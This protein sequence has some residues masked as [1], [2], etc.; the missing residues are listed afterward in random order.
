MPHCL[1]HRPLPACRLWFLAATLI[2]KRCISDPRGNLCPVV[3]TIPPSFYKNSTAQPKVLIDRYQCRPRRNLKQDCS[4]FRRS[5]TGQ[6]LSCERG[7][8]SHAWCTFHS[9]SRGTRHSGHWPNCT[10]SMNETPRSPRHHLLYSNLRTNGFMW[11]S[12]ARTLRSNHSK[13]EGKI[14]GKK[15]ETPHTAHLDE[16]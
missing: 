8:C 14:N 5:K 3:T 11:A 16:G 6:R 9:S 15:I 10:K 1:A 7:I 2:P 13:D 4:I 12:A